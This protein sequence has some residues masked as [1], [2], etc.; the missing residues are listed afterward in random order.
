LIPAEGNP[1]WLFPT[2]KTDFALIQDNLNSIALRANIAAAMDPHSES[3]NMAIRDMHLSAESIRTNILEVIPYTYI[4][5][6]NI[7]L[8]GL[9]IAAI[10]IIFAAMRKIKTTT[11]IQYKTV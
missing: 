8:T 1:V 10:I 11:T 9:W 2:A 4:T 7:A 6:S 5:L 3:Y